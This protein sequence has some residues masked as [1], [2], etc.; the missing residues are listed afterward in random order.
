MNL[1][2]DRVFLASYAVSPSEL[3]Q[4]EID[5][6]ERVYRG[7]PEDRK[8][9]LEHRQK[10]QSIVRDLE[11]A[12][13]KYIKDK[14]ESAEE[15][16][17]AEASQMRDLET[18][19]KKHKQDLEGIDEK[20]KAVKRDVFALDKKLSKLPDAPKL[21]YPATKQ[22]G[23]K[24]KKEK[25]PAKPAIKYPI[26]DLNINDLKDPYM[27]KWMEEE[28]SARTS[29]LLTVSDNL[30]LIGTRSLGIKAPSLDELNRIIH[31]ASDVESTG[32]YI[33][34]PG[35]DSIRQLYHSIIEFL[36]NENI[37]TGK[38]SS[39]E[40]R[41][42]RVISEGTW[43]EILRRFVLSRDSDARAVYDRPDSHATLAVSM[44]SYDPIESLTFD[45]HVSILYYLVNDVL[46][47]SNAV[48]DLLQSTYSKNAIGA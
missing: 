23:L 34:D 14:I 47:N 3:K 41:W 29:K 43:P 17:K 22:N 20:I 26:E 21:P 30:I 12:K 25:A 2:K 46:M 16:K 19:I 40:K 13:E 36:L 31:E 24:M 37:S 32:E 10:V 39:A 45:Q 7:D 15:M 9:M 8:G 28:S 5:D 44:L 18:Q 38:A 27:P 11:K 42:Y 33:R 48:R 4:F 6:K 1:I 35:A